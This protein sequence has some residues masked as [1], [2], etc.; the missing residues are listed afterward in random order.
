MQRL[1]WKDVAEFIGIAA[2][3]ASLVFVGMQIRQDRLFGLSQS[4]GDML[5]NRIESRIGHNV[6]ADLLARANAGDE[7]SPAEYIALRNVVENEQDIVFLH[8]WRDTVTGEQQTN[9]PELLFA[10][11]LF[12]N[13]GA[14]AVWL[15]LE[16]EME[17][18]VKPLRSEESLERTQTTGSAA[19]RKRIK[20]YLK[21]LEE[22]FPEGYQ[23]PR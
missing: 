22:R 13:P 12:R 20:G 2:I 7:L 9:T 16:Y 18:L 6:H 19:F 4:V 5:E 3:V 15:E 14:R 23:P 10:A 1:S 11:Y 8:A 17:T 21:R